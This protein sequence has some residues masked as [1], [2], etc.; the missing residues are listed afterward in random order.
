MWATVDEF[1][2][3]DLAGVKGPD[4]HGPGYMTPGF[5]E[6]CIKPYIP[7]DLEH[8][9]ASIR[10]VRGV[11]SAGWKKADDSLT[12]DVTIPVNSEA[13]VSVP[14]IGLRNGA[15]EE[16]GKVTWK[17]GSYVSGVAGITWGS[18]GADYIT[19]HV[20]SGAYSLKLSGTL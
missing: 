2:Y 1:F 5:R 4:Y 16:S 13:K 12:L 9:S 20:G 18:E 6:L 7:D 11:V 17:D 8:A 10:T 3:N 14:K 15:I 19:L